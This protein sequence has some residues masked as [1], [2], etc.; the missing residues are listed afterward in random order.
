L[1]SWLYFILPVGKS[2]EIASTGNFSYIVYR[3][4]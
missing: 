3:I 2:Q 1:L 4:S